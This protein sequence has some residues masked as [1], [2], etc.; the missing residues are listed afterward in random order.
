MVDRSGAKT[1]ENAREALA[2]NDQQTALVND[3]A[4]ET[5]AKFS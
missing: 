4:A 2:L 5:V 3:E 1:R